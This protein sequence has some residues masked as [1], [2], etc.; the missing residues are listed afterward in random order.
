MYNKMEIYFDGAAKK[1]P[2]PSGVGAVIIYEGKQYPYYKAIGHATNNQAEY[3]G[4]ILG[5]EE[6]RKLDF[7][8]IKDIKDIKVYG[9]SNLVI[10][11]MSGLWKIN[12]EEL[13]KLWKYAHEIIDELQLKVSFIHIPR[14]QNSVADRLAN[15]ALNKI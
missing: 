4:L 2:G 1:N 14:E 10:K 12:N 15:M 8:D 6:L 11:Q 13:R 9:D 5:L 3:N 7:K